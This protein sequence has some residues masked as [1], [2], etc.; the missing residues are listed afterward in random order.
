MIRTAITKRLKR[1]DRSFPL[2][3]RQQFVAI[4]ALLGC[5]FLFVQV[6]SVEWRYPLTATLT[7]ATVVL[8]A[9]GLREDLRGIEWFMLLSL[10]TLYTMSVSLFYFLLPVRWLTRIPIALLYTVGMYALLLTENIF[11][12][13]A[14]RTIALLRAAHSVGFLV[15]LVTYFLSISVL[16]TLRFPIGF[17]M[18]L[19]SIVSFIL[20][21]QALWSVE[22]S[23]K[24]P[25]R[26]W[27]ISIALAAVLTEL[28]WIF[29]FWPVQP[30]LKA[31]FLTTCLYSSVGMAQQ[32]VLE[33][34]YRKTT[35]EFFSLAMIVLCI[36][37]LAS[38]WRGYV[39]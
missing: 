17:H 22:L 1:W 24:P 38:H 9:F 31:L 32:Y 25:R 39:Y 12:V 14:G 34:L 7:V 23:E 26:V 8:T 30:T 16:F 3:K 21:I 6:A 33:K 11:N 19:L 20:I 5:G 4:T 10:P 28:S 27:Q 37:L 35:I 36:I 13:A 2:S 15:T 18:F 29:S